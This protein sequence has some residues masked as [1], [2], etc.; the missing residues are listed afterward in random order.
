MTDVSASL[1]QFS[2]SG[3]SSIPDGLRSAVSDLPVASSA[4]EDGHLAAVRSAYPEGDVRADILESAAGLA[5]SGVH[6]LL[7]ATASVARL[8]ND[9]RAVEATV[10]GCEVACRLAALLDVRPD[11]LSVVGAALAGS[12]DPAGALHALGLAATQ[13]TTVSGSSGEGAE[14]QEEVAALRTAFAA[15]DGLEAALLGERGFTAPEAPV[16]GR[17][18]LLALLAPAV[19]AQELVSELG[20]RWHAE[21]VLK[22]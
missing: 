15:A 18:G 14:G 12:T 8:R 5:R 21:A 16:E 9:A 19:D 20:T 11:A 7:A 13:T 17:R 3:G 6:P 2:L 22:E 1:V 10:L 4:G